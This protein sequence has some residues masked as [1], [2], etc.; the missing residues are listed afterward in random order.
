MCCSNFSQ[1]SLSVLFRPSFKLGFFLPI[2]APYTHLGRLILKNNRVLLV[3][4]FCCACKHMLHWWIIL[5]RLNHCAEAATRKIIVSFSSISRTVCICT[6][7][8]MQNASFWLQRA[9]NAELFYERR[10]CESVSV[11]IYIYIYIVHECICMCVS[12]YR[13][14]VKIWIWLMGM[15]CLKQLL[16]CKTILI[17]PTLASRAVSPRQREKVLLKLM[18]SFLE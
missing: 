12:T 18:E 11:C 9:V 15:I 14:W 2:F 4:G 1:E 13:A 5:C 8:C 7:G 3:V 16:K 10:W 17:S 6:S